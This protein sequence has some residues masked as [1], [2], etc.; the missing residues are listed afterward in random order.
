M[1]FVVVLGIGV[2]ILGV[3]TRS[4][5]V[6]EGRPILVV[7]VVGGRMGGSFGGQGLDGMWFRW[8]E[9]GWELVLDVWDWLESSFSG[10]EFV[11]GRIPA[12]LWFVRWLRILGFFYFFFNFI[13][14]KYNLNS[15][16]IKKSL[17]NHF[18]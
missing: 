3:G 7:S 12:R 15:F 17:V 9:V 2:A 1:D 11:P 18:N 6:V 10:R 14:L 5:G 4:G 8:L 13:I 16:L